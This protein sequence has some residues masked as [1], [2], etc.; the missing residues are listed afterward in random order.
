[1]EQNSKKDKRMEP[2]IEN[3]EEKVLENTMKTTTNSKMENTM[4]N[5]TNPAQEPLTP[6]NA[7]DIES[8][9][10]AQDFGSSA[11]VK[12]VVTTVP[13]RKPGKQDFIMVRR[14]EEWKLTVAVL[15]LKED[16]EHY[17]VVPQMVPEILNEVTMKQLVVAINRQ[18]VCFIWPL[19][20][21]GDDGRLD[22][23]S[24][25]ALE[26]AEIAEGKWVRVASN[27]SLGAY[28]I[29][30]AV[31][32]LSKPVWPD[33]SL[34]E[35]ISTAFKGKVIDSPDHLVLKRLQGLV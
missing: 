31:G 17:I 1:M 26:A 34:Q 7:I 11:G 30:E 19:R 9:R 3:Q 5:I 25:S 29:Y 12:R 22:N 28:E 2:T 24:Q 33:L 15:E 20:L 35:L 16:R 32:E 6:N 14:G 10:L 23:W 18:G 8:L 27:M 21:P 4:E 13:V